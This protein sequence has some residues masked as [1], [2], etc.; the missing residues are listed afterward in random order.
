M[1]RELRE[2]VSHVVALGARG[3]VELACDRD[4]VE[5]RGEKSEDLTLARRE[6]VDEPALVQLAFAPATRETQQL[7]DLVELHQGLAGPDPPDGAD[8]LV[9]VG[10]LS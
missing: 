3:D 9:E 10:G 6:A 5:A 8:D 4:A 2:D 1:H 7:D